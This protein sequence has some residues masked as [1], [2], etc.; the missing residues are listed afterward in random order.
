MINS[1]FFLFENFFEKVILKMTALFL[2]EFSLK[3]L[4][5][6]LMMILLQ[7]FKSEQLNTWLH[8]IEKYSEFDVLKVHFRFFSRIAFSTKSTSCWAYIFK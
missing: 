3:E 4:F 1:Y 5:T 7:N 8:Y 6:T 2:K